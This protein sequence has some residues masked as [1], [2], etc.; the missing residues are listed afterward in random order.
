MNK[1]IFTL[2]V[3][4]LLSLG[5]SVSQAQI[6]V[7]DPY[8]FCA[9]NGS[10]YNQSPNRWVTIVNNDYSPSEALYETEQ[11][12]IVHPEF[13]SYHLLLCVTTVTVMH[14]VSLKEESNFKLDGK[15]NF[16]LITEQTVKAMSLFPKLKFNKVT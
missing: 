12:M 13:N 1:T 10:C 6:W 8:C 4:Y 16:A 7:G 5:S 9:L 11:F 14:I 3:I 2:I 15:K